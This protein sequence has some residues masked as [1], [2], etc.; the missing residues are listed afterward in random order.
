MRPSTCGR[1]R[2]GSRWA[3]GPGRSSAPTC[4]SA[5][6]SWQDSPWGSSSDEPLCR[7]APRVSMTVDDLAVAGVVWNLDDLYVGPSDPT[8]DRD[9]TEASAR[10]AAF[11][12]RY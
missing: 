3:S 9:L 10:A 2:T 5:A 11:A 1:T 12:A 7:R 4:R 8:L 6:D